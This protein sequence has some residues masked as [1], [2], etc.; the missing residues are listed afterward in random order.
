[1]NDSFDKTE[2]NYQNLNPISFLYKAARV[3]PEV[4]SIIYNDIEFKWE[5]TLD[6]CKYFASALQKI[7]LKKGN[8]VGFMAANTPE[9]YEAHFSVPMAGMVL[10][11]LNYRLDAKTIAYIIEHAEIKDGGDINS[12]AF[13]RRA[14]LFMRG[15]HRLCRGGADN[16]VSVPRKS[17][18][19]ML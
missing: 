11:A 5:E 12:G 3:F 9:L 6:R 18:A 16:L 19:G 13:E 14:E 7:G 4:K 2:A 1:M 15:R 10:N 8:V 17:D